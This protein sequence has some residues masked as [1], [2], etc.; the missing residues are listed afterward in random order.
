MI[1]PSLDGKSDKDSQSHKAPE[2]KPVSLEI[3]EAAVQAVIESAKR[4]EKEEEEASAARHME[5]LKATEKMMLM[6]VRTRTMRTLTVLG[7]VLKL[8]PR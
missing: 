8:R 5:I 6:V 1:D 7:K 2:S 4:R 3:T